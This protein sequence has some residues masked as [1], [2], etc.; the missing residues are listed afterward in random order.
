MKALIDPRVMALFNPTEQPDTSLR[1]WAHKNEGMIYD[2][3]RAIKENIREDALAERFHDAQRK[4]FRL[5]V[6]LADEVLAPLAEEGKVQL[7]VRGFN[8]TL[9]C[10]EPVYSFMEELVRALT[11]W[12]EL[13]VL[14]AH[15]FEHRL[16]SS[17]WEVLNERCSQI[18]YHYTQAVECPVYKKSNYAQWSRV[19]GMPRY[20]SLLQCVRPLPPS[21]SGSWAGYMEL[22][23]RYLA[24]GPRISIYSPFLGPRCNTAPWLGDT[25]TYES[26]AHWLA[27]RLQKAVVT[28]FPLMCAEFCFRLLQ[29]DHAGAPYFTYHND[30]PLA[31]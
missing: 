19:E 16:P 15:F 28:D 29:P 18:F 2:L 17:Q 24:E 22:Y 3:E 30:I 8:I 10:S 1:L 25:Q 4:T 23:L 7:G 21:G 20:L 13:K 31:G 14:A 9:D 6:R 11:D 26:I 27:I 12:V 5:G